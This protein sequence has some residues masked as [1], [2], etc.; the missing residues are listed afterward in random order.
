MAIQQLEAR[1]VAVS[2]VNGHGFQVADGTWL[3]FSKYV[4]PQPTMPAVGAV[5]R[6]SLD[7]AGF[8][9][10]VEPADPPKVPV[11]ANNTVKLA[12]AESKATLG[13]TSAPATAQKSA[14]VA[15]Q[16]DVQIARTNALTHA[17]AI[18]T[19]NATI[20]GATVRLED[21]LACAERIENWVT[22]SA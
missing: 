10:A 12:P 13:D 17:V 1:E 4:D 7:K 15:N 3:N 2:R 18:V 6:V 14:P 20:N 8:V 9:R 5:V 19:H 22:H 21:V 16:R 11:A